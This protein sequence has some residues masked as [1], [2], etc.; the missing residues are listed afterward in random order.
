MPHEN[1][2]PTITVG[3]ESTLDTWITFSSIDE[4]GKFSQNYSGGLAEYVWEAFKT[5][6][7]GKGDEVSIDGKKDEA[8]ELLKQAK[9]MGAEVKSTL[10]GNAALESTTLQ[11]LDS[12]V[13]FLG[14]FFPKQIKALHEYCGKFYENVDFS[15]AQSFED[16]YPTS[17]ILQAVDSNRYI[18]S[19]G[20]GRRI[21]QLRSYIQKFPHVLKQVL[22]KYGKLDMI[23]LVGWHVLFANGINDQDLDLVKTRMKKIRQIVDS[24]FFTDAGGLASFKNKDRKLIYQIYSLFDILSLN[25]GELLQISQALDITAGDEFQTMSKI[26]ESSNFNTVW[27]HS[28]DYQMSL[29]KKY[30]KNILEEAQIA[31]AAAGVY[32]VENGTFPTLAGLEHRKKTRNYSEKGLAKVKDFAKKYSSEKNFNFAITPCFLARS[33]TS[34]VGAGDISAAGYTNVI[35]RA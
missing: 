35:S 28:L 32:R 19:E 12:N 27:L 21:E 1:H 14:A 3:F 4:F 8:R 18:L 26:L 34:T 23:N 22:D 16:L 2:V 33:F 10:G 20:Q 17:Y 5:V 31:S 25:Q 11:A 9:D 6:S 29:S 24:P 15:F 13:I 7:G 30:E